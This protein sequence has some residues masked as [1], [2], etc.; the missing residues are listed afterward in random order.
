MPKDKREVSWLHK[1]GDISPWCRPS[2]ADR[3]SG[4]QRKFRHADPPL[5]ASNVVTPPSTLPLKD[6][7]GDPV[8]ERPSEDPFAALP[9]EEAAEVCAQLRDI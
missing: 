9:P 6:L 5:D 1:E 3:N 7:W 4:R 8:K 2:T